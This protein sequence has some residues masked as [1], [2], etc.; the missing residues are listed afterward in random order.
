MYKLLLLTNFQKQ[1]DVELYILSVLL[2][3]LLELQ[4]NIH[5]IIHVHTSLMIT[6]RFIPILEADLFLPQK[7]GYA[8]ENF[9]RDEPGG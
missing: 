8:A 7:K 4:W 3:L 1:S 9:P 2:L 5:K 6:H